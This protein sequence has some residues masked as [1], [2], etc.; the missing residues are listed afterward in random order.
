MTRTE[1]ARKIVSRTLVF[2]RKARRE[3]CSNI[4]TNLAFQESAEVLRIPGDSY[5]MRTVRRIAR[6]EMTLMGETHLIGF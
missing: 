3:G 4:V 1:A 5:S 2:V 6:E